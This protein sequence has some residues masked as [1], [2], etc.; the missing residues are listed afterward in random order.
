MFFSASGKSVTMAANLKFHDKDEED[1]R[2]I[3]DSA[4]GTSSVISGGTF[5]AATQFSEVRG[6]RNSIMFLQER[7][8]RI[9]EKRRV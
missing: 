2:S 3:A 6:Q 8:M 7:N 5:T 9:R 4:L 1:S